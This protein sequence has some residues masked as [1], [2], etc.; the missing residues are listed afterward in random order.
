MEEVAKLAA[1][2]VGKVLQVDMGGSKAI[3]AVGKKSGDAD[4]DPVSRF[5][6]SSRKYQHSQVPC[7]DGSIDQTLPNA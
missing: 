6:A 1:Q 3:V 4:T 7:S 5:P 2:E